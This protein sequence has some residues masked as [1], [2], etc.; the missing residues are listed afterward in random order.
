MKKKKSQSIAKERKYTSKQEYEISYSKN[1]RKS[2]TVKYK[3][4]KK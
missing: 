4:S 3:T 2:K 1:K